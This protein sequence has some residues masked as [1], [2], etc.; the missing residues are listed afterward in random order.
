M[1]SFLPLAAL[2]GVAFV[3]G[4]TEDPVTADRVD[5]AAVSAKKPWVI[6]DPT[7]C[8][9]SYS[10]G[11]IYCR[12]QSDDVEAA[13]RFGAAV[14]TLKLQCH[15]PFVGDAREVRALLAQAETV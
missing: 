15:G 4:C 6:V 2:C 13:G 3:L 7:G 11:Y 9:D 10:A 1:R 5:D 14:A 8:G 12:L